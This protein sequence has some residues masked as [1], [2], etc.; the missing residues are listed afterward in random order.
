MIIEREIVMTKKEKEL[1]K[2]TWFPHY[3]MR[4]SE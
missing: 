1:N 4:V 3:I 2:Y